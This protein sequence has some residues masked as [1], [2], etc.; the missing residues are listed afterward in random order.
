LKKKNF[1]MAQM[2]VRIDSLM[3]EKNE[4]IKECK[5]LQSQIDKLKK[6]K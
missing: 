6:A 5:K 4:F 1:L 3:R 2:Q